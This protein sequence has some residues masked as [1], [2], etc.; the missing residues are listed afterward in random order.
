L[1]QILQV[2]RGVEFVFHKTV[3]FIRHLL[4]LPL[5][6][7]TFIHDGLDKLLNLHKLL[8]GRFDFGLA[9]YFTI[10]DVAKAEPKVVVDAI[11]AIL[12]EDEGTDK[13]FGIFVGRGGVTVVEGL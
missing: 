12:F 2:V 3:D 11:D 6:S 7:L 8:M 4:R 5:D 13:F 10:T 1:E 9:R